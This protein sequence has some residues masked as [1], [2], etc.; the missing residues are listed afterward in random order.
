MKT[1]TKEVQP[2]ILALEKAVRSHRLYT[3]NNPVLTRHLQDLDAQLTH[4]LSAQ[5]DLK[6]T[7]SPYELRVEDSVVYQNSSQQESFSFRLFNDGI[8]SVAFKPGLTSKETEE[9]VASLAAPR[10]E[11]ETE[12][13]SVTLFWEREFAHIEY[14]VADALADEAT[15]DDQSAQAKIEEIV[16]PKM[17]MYRAL[18]HE[19]EDDLSQDLKITLNM[20]SVGKMF[21]ERSVLSPDELG[22]IQQ[23]IT[24]CDQP[25]RLVLDF[26][27][28]VLAVL[29][30]E[31]DHEEYIKTVDVLGKVLDNNFHHGRIHIARMVMEQVHYFPERPIV[32][33]KSDPQLLSKTLKALW[34][35]HR[36]DLMVQSFNQETTGNA[37]DIETLISLMDPMSLPLLLKRVTDVVDLH[38]RRVVCNGIARLHKGDIGLFLPMLASKDIETIRTAIF[39]LSAMKNDKVVDL[40]PPLIAHP[41]Q[42][43]RKEA[44]AVLKN[45]HTTKALRLLTGL[46]QDPDMEIRILALRILSTSNNREVAHQLMAILNREEFKLKLIQERKNY[47][48]ALA[49]ILGDDFVSYLQDLLETTSWFRKPELEDQYQCATYA[50]SV[51]ASSKAKE[52]LIKS[53]Q[54]KNKAIKKFSEAALRSLGVSAST[55]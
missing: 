31:K 21:Q 26:V 37:E 54:S 24:D 30:E 50:L 41:N 40:L 3:A 51:I 53:A 4:Y 47:F 1:E 33:A 17:S 45:Y 13:D 15:S 18:S 34:P 55:P 11:T 48:Y 20:T 25:E 42:A 46:L 10:E 5:K 12:L 8:R 6:I 43:I 38:R 39:I 29:Q 49:K 23:D 7:V 19:P 2:I 9:F 44:I 27:D 36:V 32:L 14:T 52:T 28:M 35:A 16:D 22:K